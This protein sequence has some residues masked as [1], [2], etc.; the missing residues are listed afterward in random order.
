M[1]RALLKPME[2]TDVDLK[3]PHD[4]ISMIQEVER[5]RKTGKRDKRSLNTRSI[6]FI[7]SG[8]FSELTAIVRK[9]IVDQGI[10]FGAQIA[11][12]R[13]DSEVLKHVKAEDLVEFGFESEFVGRLPIKAVFENLTEDDLLDILKN[14]NNPMILGKRLDFDA[15]GIQIKFDEPALRRIAKAAYAEK[16]GARGLVSAIESA[17]LTFEKRL[18]STT[19]KI[20]P[21]TEAVIARPAKTLAELLSP[22]GASQVVD[23]FDALCLQE[24]QRVEDYVKANRDTL[25]DKYSLT[26]T[27]SRIEI[28][29]KFYCSHIMD[30]GTVIRQIKS[31]YDAIKKIELYFYKNHDINFVLEDDALDFTIEKFLDGSVDFE[32]LYRKLSEDFEYGLKLVRSKTGKNRFF[33]TQ[34]ALT[35]P[36]T[37][38]A[39]LIKNQLSVA[40]PAQD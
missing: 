6:L 11:R 29:A 28:I 13:D 15:Y 20:F 14:P 9:R 40:S 32:S 37:F 4:P 34:K 25:S 2:E 36:N 3:V 21:V 8:A 30:V 38:I 19:L 16:T 31:Y 17:L 10:G 35:D 1:Q 33:I 23:T 22:S 27:P 12:L 7:M 18:P 5:F 39:N 24:K 26:L